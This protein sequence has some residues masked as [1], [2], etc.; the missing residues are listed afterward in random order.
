MPN[1]TSKTPKILT[2]VSDSPSKINAL[3]TAIG[4]SIDAT[5][6][7]RLLPVNGKP[8]IKEMT[9]SAWPTTPN[10]KAKI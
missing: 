8:F 7:P 3:K 9:G 2:A 1:K 6:P 5:T 10:N 4:S